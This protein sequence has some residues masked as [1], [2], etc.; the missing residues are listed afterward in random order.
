L[1]KDWEKRARKIRLLLLDVDGVLT[2]GR[3]IYDG[4]GQEWKFFNVKD[5]HGIKLLQRAGIEVGILSGRRS[6][7]V[8][9]RARELKID[10]VLQRAL[11]KGKALETIQKKKEISLSEVC[12]VGDDLVDLPVFSRVGFAVAVADS[13]AEV[14]KKAHFVTRL[15]G[16][17]GAVRE[18]CE[19]LLRAQR[20]WSIVT[21]KYFRFF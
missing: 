7:A 14:K 5:G 15:P 19:L 18:V 8:T 17:H 6:S 21:Q 1:A 9:H 16:G 10:L 12:Y 20:K 13:V 2:D 11:D 3:I 4:K